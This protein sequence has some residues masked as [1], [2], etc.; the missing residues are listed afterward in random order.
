[1]STVHLGLQYD[2]FVNILSEAGLVK[3]EDSKEDTKEGE[4]PKITKEQV[5]QALNQV[6]VLDGDNEDE[7]DPKVLTYVDFLDALVRV[8]AYYP[9]GENEEYQTMEDK[10]NYLIDKLQGKFPKIHEEFMKS[11]EEEDNTKEFNCKPVIDEN[12]DAEGESGEEGEEDD[13]EY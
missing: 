3:K 8:A 13:G 6:E 1:M 11:L 9:F 7:D 4:I 12:E 2:D 10:L 5:L